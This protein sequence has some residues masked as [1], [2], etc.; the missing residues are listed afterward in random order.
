M[1]VVT[2]LLCLA[3]AACAGTTGLDTDPPATPA[4]PVAATEPA[5]ADAAPAARPSAPQAARGTS[6]PP[7]PQPTPEVS[8]QER[9]MQARTDCWSEVDKQRA[10][11]T[12][13]TRM[14]WVEKC[15]AD[16]T[17]ARAGR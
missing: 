6:A 10:L 11:R 4:A 2:V 3:L 1:R 16:R 9:L 5:A 7:A 12:I 13:D 8:P 14:A 15:I 17:K